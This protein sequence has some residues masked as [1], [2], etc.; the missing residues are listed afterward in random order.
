M[1]IDSILEAVGNTPLLR[2]KRFCAAV[3][4]PDNIYAKL[5]MFN[6]YSVKDRAA[7]SMLD[8]ASERGKLEC[9][10]EATSGNT[11][12]GLCM[13]CAARGIPITVV[14]PENATE[15]RKKIMA[16]LGATLV[17]TDKSEGMAG[18]NRRAK[19]IAESTRGAI[20]CSQFDNPFNPKAHKK[21]AEE[22]LADTDGKV[23]IFVSAVGTG[24]TFS[25]VTRVLKAKNADLKA[26][27]VEPSASAVLSGGKA[28]AHK[29]PGIGAGFVPDN[30]D[31]S[32]CDGIITV[33]DDDALETSKLLAK[34]EG[35]LAG[36]SSGAALFACAELAKKYADKRIV[37]VFPDSFERYFSMSL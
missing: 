36:I 21:T 7:V 15:E 33:S 16:L 32:L 29:I 20:M 6:P 18:A 1:R 26:F 17:L 27:A 31:R 3:G 35:V 13:A 9:V 28:G 37:T 10:V 24:G 12:I 2:L 22:I 8:G 5:E 25:G 11:G 34:T 30:F 23:D 14:M 4:L 19:E